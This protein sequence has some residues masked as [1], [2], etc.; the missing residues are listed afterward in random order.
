[1]GALALLAA[2]GSTGRDVAL[3]VQQMELIRAGM[4]YG[5]RSTRIELQKRV[6]DAVTTG[7]GWET[8][9]P[10]VRKASDTPWFKSFLLFDP[11]ATVMK[12]Q[13]PILIVHG[14]LDQDVSPAHAEL[15][16]RAAGARKPSQRTTT[17]KAVIPGVNHLFVTQ[18]GKTISPDLITTL[19]AWFKDAIPVKK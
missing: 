10:D 13:Q 2:H 14:A 17:K 5:E 3:E 16:D 18:Q 11:A 7:K 6:L 19:T 8:L 12:I 4:A 9:P 15:L 1:V